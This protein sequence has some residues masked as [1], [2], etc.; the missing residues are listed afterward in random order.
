[1]CIR[2]RMI[3]ALETQL[4]DYKIIHNQQLDN[5]IPPAIWFNPVPAGVV[6]AGE[7]KPINWNLPANVALPKDLN[8]L[9][10]YSVADLSV[11][12]RTRKITSVELTKFFLG[13][14]KT[15]SYTHLDVY[16]RQYLG[17]GYFNRILAYYRI[18]AGTWFWGRKHDHGRKFMRL[19][20]SFI[21]PRK[22]LLLSF[23]RQ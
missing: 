1:M 20:R 9:A 13:R 7:Q 12:I 14:L 10:W 23:W 11:L 16:K 15:V 19:F 8:E 21:T 3:D 4:A 5:S 2:D 6:F 17:R 18:C 22:F